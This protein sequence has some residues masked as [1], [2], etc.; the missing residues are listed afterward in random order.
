[1]KK[2]TYQKIA[3]SVIE[4]DLQ[5]GYTI[6]VII[7]PNKEENN[8]EASLELKDNETSLYDLMGDFEHLTIKTTDRTIYSTV[9]KEV[10][11][12]MGNNK[13]DKYF[14]RYEYMLQCFDLGNQLFEPESMGSK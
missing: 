11:S 5:N 9:L 12:L 2:L 13:F 3:N 14:E 8:Y 4:I 10:A 6:R 7:V 1:M